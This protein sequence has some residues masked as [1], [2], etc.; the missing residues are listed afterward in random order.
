MTTYTAR[1]CGCGHRACKSW[2][3][4]PVAAVWGVSFTEEQAELVAQVLNGGYEAA[5]KHLLE[6]ISTAHS[7][8][9]GA[10]YALEFD[11]MRAISRAAVLRT[12]SELCKESRP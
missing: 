2:H 11:T 4:W 1:P 6:V 3:V 8:G 7:V 5:V 12:V 10:D 9:G